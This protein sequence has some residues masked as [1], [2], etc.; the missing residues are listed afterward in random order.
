MVSFGEPSL[1][2]GRKPPGG[3]P[4]PST[5]PH[6]ADEIRARGTGKLDEHWQD[7]VGQLAGATLADPANKFEVASDEMRGVVMVL[8][9]L[10][11]SISL[12]QRTLHRAIE[13]A[14]GAGYVV[15]D[16][17]SLQPMSVRLPMLIDRR[18]FTMPKRFHPEPARLHT[19]SLP[20]NINIRQR[21]LSHTLPS[22]PRT[23]SLPTRVRDLDLDI[24]LQI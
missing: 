5:R 3:L 24:Q 22:Q 6:C 23:L 21:R 14:L 16:D 2:F 9:A 15:A 17:G 1:I 8:D 4:E 18:R 10:A 13:D 11:E 19:M 12:A 20:V 7:N